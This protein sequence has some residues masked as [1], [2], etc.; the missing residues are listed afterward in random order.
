M[1]SATSP[2]AGGAMAPAGTLSMRLASGTW[3]VAL[4]TG[5]LST[6]LGIAI[7]VWP[8]ATVEVVAVLVGINFILMGIYRIAQAIVV[9]EARGGTRALLAVLGVLSL[10]IGVLALRHLLQTVEVLAILF[11]LFWLIVG[12]IELVTVSS[13]PMV[14]GRGAA[15]GLAI[16]SMLAGIAMLA[17]PGMTLLALTWILG[18]W[19][20]TW[21]VLT[22]ALTLWLHHAEKRQAA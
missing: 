10:V 17:F 6:L 8:K 7:V 4:T 21:G 16:L 12:V 2:G 15:I 9:S 11:G 13:S 22:I 5:V 14:S 3:A 18:F 19:L 20:I 1:A